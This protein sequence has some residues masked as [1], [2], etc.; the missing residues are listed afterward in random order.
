M[1]VFKRMGD[2]IS[3]NLNSALDKLEDPEKMID[4]AISRLE[5]SIA[6]M[7]VTIAEKTAE[8]KRL[9][10]LVEERKATRDRWQDRAKLAA[11][12]NEDT[13]AREAI[14]EKL[15]LDAIINADEN[16][17]SSIASILASLNESKAKAEETLA[18]MRIKSTE[19]KLRAKSAKEKIKV[20]NATSND[21]NA[22]FEKRIA[23][24]RA[25]IDKWEALADESAVPLEKEENKKTFESMEREAAI[26]EELRKL[27]SNL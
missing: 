10:A 16:S 14:A 25:K 27:K 4:L 9:T 13:L 8:Y 5:D 3:S 22:K 1:N 7:K 23:E 19:L 6:K 15:K 18:S 20:N 11:D 24:I 17:L 26:E 2:I 12:K 21:E